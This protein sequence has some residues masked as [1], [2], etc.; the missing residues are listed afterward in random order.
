MGIAGPSPASVSA[1]SSPQLTAS[2]RSGTPAEHTWASR[3]AK[4][5]AR[6][7]RVWSSTASGCNCASRAATWAAG[8][9]C[10]RSSI[11][12]RGQIG[13]QRPQP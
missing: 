3:S 7:I 11:S 5:S 12:P 1:D 9:C 4:A 13:R 6:P 8:R 2:R 10:S